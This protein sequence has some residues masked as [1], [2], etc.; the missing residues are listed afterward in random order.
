MDTRQK[1]IRVSAAL[2]KESGPELSM[3]AVCEAAGV[4]APT[5][6]HHF[7]DKQGLIDATVAD[8]FDRY[9][10]EKL[11][12]NSTGNLVEDLRR[13]WDLHVDF[14]RSNPVLYMLMFPSAN[15]ESLPS[16]AE[17]SFALLRR[18]ME[19][20]EQMGQLQPSLH[21]DI[22]VRA[23]WASLYG[24]TILI[25]SDKQQQD[26]ELL[27][28]LVRDAVIDALTCSPYLREGSSPDHEKS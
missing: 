21:A 5:L 26:A 25:C 27:S 24:T 11:N 23:L 20:L 10:A 1:L 22:A 16:A 15:R 4:T 2:L 17:K 14:G 13:G 7:G 18:A 3:R 9:L 19:R 6:Y 8:A 28:A 12:K